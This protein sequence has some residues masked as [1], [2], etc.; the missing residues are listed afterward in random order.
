M[1]R[2]Q[3]FNDYIVNDVMRDIPGITSRAMFGGWGIYQNGVFFALIS[4]G[5]LYFK[6]DESNIGD[7]KKRGSRPF[8]YESKGKKMEMSY[9]LIPEEILEDRA[10]LP[11][12]IEKSVKANSKK[13]NN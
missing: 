12:W 7:Y 10:E 13:K 11:F 2:D 1:A 9:W 6:V 3:D 8:V 5:E 4:D